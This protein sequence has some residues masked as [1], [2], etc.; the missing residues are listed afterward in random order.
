[1]ASGHLGEYTADGLRIRPASVNH[2]VRLRW[3][4]PERAQRWAK[5]LAALDCEVALEG[6]DVHVSGSHEILEYIVSLVT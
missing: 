5:D 4:S 1:M 6:N 2:S 3:G